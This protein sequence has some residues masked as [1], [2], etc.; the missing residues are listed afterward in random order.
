MYSYSVTQHLPQ[1][2][3]FISELQQALCASFNMQ[4]I[5]SGV[6]TSC[7]PYKREWLHAAPHF[8]MNTQANDYRPIIAQ[9]TSRARFSLSLVDTL[10]V[11]VEVKSIGQSR[12]IE[13][14]D[15]FT[16]VILKPQELYLLLANFESSGKM[17][18]EL[19]RR[20]TSKRSS[21]WKVHCSSGKRSFSAWRSND[22]VGIEVT[23]QMWCR[24]LGK[25]Y[26]G[27]LT[28]QHKDVQA[29][30][31]ARKQIFKAIKT[32]Y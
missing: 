8:K 14:S 3:D 1:E 24:T 15:D 30:L 29:I 2:T 17:K 9:W 32:V 6:V 4:P 21:A 22:I 25:P 5:R 23:D 7:V 16:T 20:R 18:K 19:F 13:I 31:K 12:I 10:P 27:D 28:L 11:I 26:V